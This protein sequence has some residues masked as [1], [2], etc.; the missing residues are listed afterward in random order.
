MRCN[1]GGIEPDAKASGFC[2]IGD[3]NRVLPGPEK[4]VEDGDW[5][6]AKSKIHLNDTQCEVSAPLFLFVARQNSK[7]EY[8]G[9]SEDFEAVPPSHK[10]STRFHTRQ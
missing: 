9:F 2:L 1:H 3:R 10:T 6:R 4:S 7:D 5:V 8:H